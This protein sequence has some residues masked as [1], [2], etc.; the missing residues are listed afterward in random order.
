MILHYYF[1][2]FL[3]EI[4]HKLLALRLWTH[5]AVYSNNVFGTGSD[6]KQ[7]KMPSFV[8]DDKTRILVLYFIYFYTTRVCIDANDIA[9][10]LYRMLEKS[11]GDDK[12]HRECARSL[13]HR[14]RDSLRRRI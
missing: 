13:A 2:F 12:M 1:F 5:S 6:K 8:A 10:T 4:T 14:R 11:R 9:R 7:R 3:R